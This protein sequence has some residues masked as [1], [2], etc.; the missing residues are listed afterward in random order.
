MEFLRRK[1]RLTEETKQRIRTAIA[2]PARTMLSIEREFDIDFKTVKKFRTDTEDRRL[3][4][5]YPPETYVQ[6]ERD[7]RAGS[8][9]RD[10]ASSLGM[11]PQTLLRHVPYRKKAN[12][13]E[14]QT[15]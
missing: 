9:W 2:D 3:R 13:H 7:L 15:A 8:Y 12:A 5:K 4:T 14:P 6:A 11:S 10:V 1:R